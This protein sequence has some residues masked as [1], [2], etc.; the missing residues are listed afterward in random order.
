MNGL[1]FGHK[2]EEKNNDTI[3]KNTL[4]WCV[5]AIRQIKNSRETNG[6]YL[7]IELT[8]LDNQPYS[9]RKIWDKIADPF[10]TNNSEEWRNM[11]Y[12]AIRRIL[13]AVKG[14]TPE[15]ANSYSLN[16]LEDLH[17]LTVPVLIG[18]EKGKDGYEDKNRVDYLTP[19][20]T[21]KKIVECYRLLMSGQNK[22]GNDDKPAVPTQGSMFTGTASPPP[23]G[24]SP[25]AG[26]PAAAPAAS[27]AP[28]WL[29]PAQGALAPQQQY[30]APAPQQP[31]YA[32]P[33][34]QPAGFPQGTAPAP[35]QGYTAPVNAVPPQSAPMNTG[36]PAAPAGAYPSNQGWA[37]PAGA[38]APAQ[39][40]TGHNNGK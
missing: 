16:R 36:H 12:L 7:D 33:Q 32:P 2:V 6:R 40:L 22:Y 20:S 9:R 13:E 10:D 14:A 27:S 5:L 25:P 26:A 38:P 19:H 11:G 39:F 17:G 30:Q 35:Q 37:P 28:G 24:F 34:G 31:A 3:P 8:V 29:A 15:N 1:N 21:Q 4:L 23:A 18:I